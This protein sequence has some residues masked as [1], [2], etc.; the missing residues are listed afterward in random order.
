MALELKLLVKA[1]ASVTRI[2]LVVGEDIRECYGNVLGRVRAPSAPVPRDQ[3][4]RPWQR[5]DDDRQAALQIAGDLAGRVSHQLDVAVEVAGRVAAAR[6][7]KRQAYI[8]GVHE[9]TKVRR[10]QRLGQDRDMVG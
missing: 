7:V 8:G 6:I 10:R 9:S 1:L 2:A 5:V 4:T 3:V